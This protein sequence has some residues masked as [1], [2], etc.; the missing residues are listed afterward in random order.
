MGRFYW[1]AMGEGGGVEGGVEGK[2]RLRFGLELAPL[3]SVQ[4]RLKY[5]KSQG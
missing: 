3:F 5:K 4:V 1:L 2:R